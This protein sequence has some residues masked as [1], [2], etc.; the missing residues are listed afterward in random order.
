MSKSGCHRSNIV[1]GQMEYDWL[2]WIEYWGWI[3]GL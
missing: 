1:R 2:S 3:D